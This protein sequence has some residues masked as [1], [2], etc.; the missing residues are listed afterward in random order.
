M[1]LKSASRT[2][3]SIFSYW[4][5]TPRNGIIEREWRS[6]DQCLKEYMKFK[7]FIFIEQK[8]NG[9]LLIA[10]DVCSSQPT[11]QVA[12]SRKPKLSTSRRRIN[13][14]SAHTNKN[15]WLRRAIIGLYNS[16]KIS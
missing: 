9:F 2:W 1:P 5:I 13:P 15:K 14:A 6:T 16:A 8:F 11:R 10:C 12:D 7:S 4:R 3:K